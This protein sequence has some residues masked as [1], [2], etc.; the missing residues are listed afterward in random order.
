MKKAVIAFVLFFTFLFLS[1]APLQPPETP[2][3]FVTNE[4]VNAELQKFSDQE[5]QLL[6]S[7]LEKEL[8]EGQMQL[9]ELVVSKEQLL[10]LVQE[11]MQQRTSLTEPQEEAQP[12]RRLTEA[13]RRL[14]TTTP[15][16]TR[17][18]PKTTAPLPKKITQTGLQAKIKPGSFLGSVTGAWPESAA[19]S[20]TLCSTFPDDAFKVKRSAPLCTSTTGTLRKLTII[21]DLHAGNDAS[22]VYHYNQLIRIVKYS[23]VQATYADLTRTYSGTDLLNNLL[24]TGTDLLYDGSEPYAGTEAYPPSISAEA[25]QQ[26][27]IWGS[28]SRDITYDLGFVFGTWDWV[29]GIPELTNGWYR[30]SQGVGACDG[31][32]LNKIRFIRL[33]HPKNGEVIIHLSRFFPE[34]AYEGDEWCPRTITGLVGSGAS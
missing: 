26:F 5:L 8:P 21:N 31:S 14:P 33:K 30:N 6:L 28:V 4:Q 29:T 22:G 16:R 7:E 2:Q 3:P 1:C 13:G 23:D 24:E 17:V 25:Q 34:Y 20:F 18:A 11:E 32:V 27:S 10:P 19:A 15:S 9:A 12:Q